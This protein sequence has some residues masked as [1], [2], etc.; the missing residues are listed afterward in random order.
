M[1]SSI[2]FSQINSFPLT[3]VS[4]PKLKNYLGNPQIDQRTQNLAKTKIACITRQVIPSM[5]TRVFGVFTGGGVL[6]GKWIYS[7][8]IED[9]HLIMNGRQSTKEDLAIDKFLNQVDSLISLENVSAFNPTEFA[10]LLKTLKGRAPLQH[11]AVLEELAW[12][13]GEELSV[14]KPNQGLYLLIKSNVEKYLLDSRIP[15]RK[16]TSTWNKISKLMGVLFLGAGARY[17]FDRATSPS[18]QI[19]VTG[20]FGGGYVLD[21][22]PYIP[23]EFPNLDSGYAIYLP[24]KGYPQIKNSDDSKN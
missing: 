11:S 8:D 23:S 24:I 18:L 4:M 22:Y 13:L 1:S 19:A 12:Q 9:R 7:V 14:P 15:P 6:N 16:V 10:A 3:F 21:S 20:P 17:L 2:S 5:G